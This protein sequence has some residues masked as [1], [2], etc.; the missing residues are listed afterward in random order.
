MRDF[1]RKVRQAMGKQQT[2]FVRELVADENELLEYYRQMAP[3]FRSRFFMSA[4]QMLD[5]QI[6]KGDDEYELLNDYLFYAVENTEDFLTQCD[7][8]EQ[9][10]ME[11]EIQYMDPII[12]TIDRGLTS[13]GIFGVCLGEVF[14]IDFVVEQMDMYRLKEYIN[15]HI[16]T[17]ED[18]EK[19]LK[20]RGYFEL[21][22]YE[23]CKENYM[24]FRESLD[25]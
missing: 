14:G 15:E 1:I 12:I 17:D 7:F 20:A 11:P 13:A 8:I 10:K 4:I 19:Q 16:K 2:Q 5:M 24:T 18:F 23:I 3:E 6:E 9:R 21:V 22:A 25:L